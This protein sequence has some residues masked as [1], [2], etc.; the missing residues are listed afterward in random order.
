ML[1]MSACVRYRPMPRHLVVHVCFA[2]SFLF[3]FIYFALCCLWT[4]KDV[5]NGARRYSLL[6]VRQ[7]RCFRLFG[8]LYTT[9]AVGA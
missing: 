1:S 5:T 8:A 4:N 3:C 6:V 9:A 7:V 2:C